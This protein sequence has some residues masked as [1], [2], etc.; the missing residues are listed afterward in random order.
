MG[1]L[2]PKRAFAQQSTGIACLSLLHWQSVANLC[3]FLA[4]PLASFV[5]LS[6]RRRKEEEE[7]EGRKEKVKDSRL[8]IYCCYVLQVKKIN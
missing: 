4:F 1:C 8:N 3:I 7:E 5:C 6:M 2:G